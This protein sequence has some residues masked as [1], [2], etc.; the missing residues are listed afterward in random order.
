MRQRTKYVIAGV[1]LVLAVSVVGGI[2]VSRRD[3]GTAVRAEEV[4][5]RELVAT[6]RSSGWIRPRRAVEI[7][8]DIMG[9]IV[10]LRVDEGDSVRVGDLLLRID[11]TQYEAAVMRAE[12]AVSGALAR[13]AQTR[14]AYLQAEQSLRRARDLAAGGPNLVSAQVLEEAE[15]QVAVQRA[16][17]EASRH[18]VAQARAALREAQDRLSKTVIRAPISGVV[19]RRNVEEGE[20]AI[21]GTMNNPGSLLLTISDLSVME[22]VVRV[23]ETD[24]PQLTLG[25]SAAVEIDAFPRAKF[26]GRITKIGHSGVGLPGGS[27]SMAAVARNQ[28]I[29]FEVVITLDN[30]PA[31]LRPDLSATANIVTAT[32]PDALAIPIIALTVRERPVE[33]VAQEDQAARAASD[34]AVEDT[35]GVFL[36]RAGKAHFVAVEVGIAGADYFEVL[37]GLAEGDTVVAGPYD[38]IRSLEDQRPVRRSEN[39]RRKGGRT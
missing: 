39:P 32:R 36:I 33:A 9:R 37:A 5:R 30:P 22:A 21:V 8:A 11:P 34:R 26:A 15:T 17:Q 6:V 14:A 13:E 24:V 28:A 7:Q 29:D 2:S 4:S 27:G 3:K 31:G 23:D 1:G 20:M 16:L 19:T 18:D 25:D 35:E 38:A 12:A 10:E